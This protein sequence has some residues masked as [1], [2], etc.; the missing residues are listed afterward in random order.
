MRI[1][2]NQAV[3]L[4]QHNRQQDAKDA[5]LRSTNGHN[6]AISKNQASSAEDFLELSSTAKPATQEN[7][8][9]HSNTANQALS[10]KSDTELF[11]EK[12]EEMRAE[13]SELM[14]QIRAAGEAGQ[15]MA[16]SM[17]QKMIA[18]KIAMRISNGDNVPRE[19]HR[20]LME[21]D[22]G[23]YNQAV[24]MGVIARNNNPEDYDSLLEEPSENNDSGSDRAGADIPMPS[25]SVG[26]D[27]SSGGSESGME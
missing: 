23:L 2:T 24:N 21:F 6:T 10:E 16:E 18:L 22:A 5:K 1:G 27:I 15:G 3:R 13:G 7:I 4:P 19:D 26:S 9:L 17:R 14:K 25:G 20:F 8:I 11:R 12:L